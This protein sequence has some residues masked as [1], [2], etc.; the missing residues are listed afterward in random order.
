MTEA[1]IRVFERD[2][3]GRMG[4]VE[5]FNVGELVGVVPQIGDLFVYPGVTQGLDRHDPANR[6]VSLMVARY[7][8]PGTTV[9][10]KRTQ[11]LS[12]R[13]VRESSTRSTSFRRVAGMQ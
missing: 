9:E 12:W 3:D 13:D 7:I 2:K 8:Q 4:A 5:D 6:T 11:R 10:A 1:M